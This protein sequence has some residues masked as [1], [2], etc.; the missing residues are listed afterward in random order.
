MEPRASTKPLGWIT[1]RK[2]LVLL[3]AL[4]LLILLFQLNKLLSSSFRVELFG[5]EILEVKQLDEATA[6]NGTFAIPEV[7]PVPPLPPMPPL[8]PTAPT[9]EVFVVVEQMP[10]LIGGLRSIQ[11]EIRYPE[12]AKRAG[13]E[14]R[15]IVQFIVDEQGRV[16]EPKI[17]RG[18]G[19]GCDEEALRVVSRARFHPGKQHGQS[20]KV[21]MS[22][23]LMFKLR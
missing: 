6:G 2:S 13:L 23:P 5:L 12:I 4:G 9:P 1:T 3:T 14:G 17:V 16:I 8:P 18:I 20:V 11:Q 7:P 22:L 21:K 19:G 10:E 15:V